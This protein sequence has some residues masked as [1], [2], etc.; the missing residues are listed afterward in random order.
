L[1]PWTGLLPTRNTSGYNEPATHSGS[2]IRWH[3]LFDDLFGFFPRHLLRPDINA[4]ER[5]HSASFALSRCL[6]SVGTTSLISPIRCFRVGQS[7]PLHSRSL[8]LVPPMKAHGADLV[9]S[10]RRPYG[11]DAALLH[12]YFA[13]PNL[14]LPARKTLSVRT[15]LVV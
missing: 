7:V 11:A 12:P 5:P 10:R 8:P 3:M 13:L 9:W 14:Y 1:R 4:A 6:S 2:M 15:A